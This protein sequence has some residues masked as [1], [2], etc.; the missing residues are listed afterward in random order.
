MV[1]RESKKRTLEVALGHRGQV[2][3]NQQ[4]VGRAI[5]DG[6]SVGAVGRIE[7]TGQPRLQT[8]DF[9]FFI[10]ELA[11][12]YDNENIAKA[13]QIENTRVSEWRQQHE[14]LQQAYFE[15]YGIP[16]PCNSQQTT[17]LANDDVSLQNEVGPT[18]PETV[19]SSLARRK[20]SSYN[21]EFKLKAVE[22]AELS[23]NRAAAKEFRVHDKRI[24]EWRKNKAILLTSPRDRKRLRG[25]GRKGPPLDESH[26]ENLLFN[27]LDQTMKE[28]KPITTADLQQKA[29]QLSVSILPKGSSF[30]ASKDWVERFLRN[31]SL[32]TAE[33][34]ISYDCSSVDE[35]KPMIGGPT[36]VGEDLELNI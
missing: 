6:D 25:A 17:V 31:H 36:M 18:K 26:L 21:T 29:I 12:K 27:W 33:K 2:G 1:S 15:K 9:K 13:F 20:K 3:L 4:L 19:T 32:S 28:S 16:V 34:T 5:N 30:S 35:T 11:T 24:R 10:S 7:G 23:T 22:F 8:I 14:L